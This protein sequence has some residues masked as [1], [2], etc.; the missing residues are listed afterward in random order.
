MYKQIKMRRVHSRAQQLN[1]PT[2]STQ[3]VPETKAT[4]CTAAPEQRLFR[5]KQTQAEQISQLQN[6]YKESYDTYE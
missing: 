6:T 3:D 4:R 5:N 1:F 2:D